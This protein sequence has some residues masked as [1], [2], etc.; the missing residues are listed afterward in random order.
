MLAI[1]FGACAR[2]QHYQPA[3]LAPADEASAYA[4]RRLDDPVLARV[5][6]AHGIPTRDSVWDSRQLALAALYFRPDLTEAERALAAAHAAEITAGVRPY[7]S[8]TITADRAAKA[9]EGHT[10][11]WS[12]SLASGFT[13]E[14]GGKRGARIGR[15]RAITLAARLRLESTAWQAIASARQAGVAALGA[16]VDLVD[17]RAETTSLRAVLEL[18][19]GRYSEGQIS[20]SDLARSETDVQTSSVAATQAAGA[21]VD[22]RSALAR[23]LAVSVRQVDQLPIRADSR[24]ACVAI[25]SL[26]VDTLE[27]LSLRTLSVVGAALADYSV[28][29]AD[30]RVQIAQ[31][32]PD[33][34][35]GPGIAWEQ[36]VRRWILSLGLPSIAIDRA[37]GPIA[38]AVARRAVQAARVKLVQDAVLAAVDSGVATCRH[39]QRE[40]VVADSLVRTSNEQVALAQAAYQRGEIGRTEIA[41]AQ[42]A[43]VRA[44]RTR[45]QAAQRALAAGVALENATGLWLSGP[46]IDWRDIVIPPDDSVH[47]GRASSGIPQ[48]KRR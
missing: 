11:P 44:E 20:R 9:D 41:V 30:L 38:E 15:A 26:P 4:A 19:H 37:R 12:F 47:S 27:T 25:D 45:H 42:L 48:Q 6:A 34:V 39:V 5:L 18:L 1:Q 46:S 14:R 8:V 43:S 23:A 21:R 16:D 35:L 3:P 13:L 32:Y 7:P 17:V 40:I 33:V 2:Y 36:G 22:S 28:A 10:T 29:E 31:Q 24:A